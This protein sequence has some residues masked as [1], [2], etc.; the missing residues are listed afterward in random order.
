MS[1]SFFLAALWDSLGLS[2]T[3][4]R[5]RESLAPTPGP[6]H[7]H[8]AAAEAL[9][10]ASL[11]ACLPACPHLESGEGLIRRL[12]F[13]CLTALSDRQIKLPDCQIEWGTRRRTS[14]LKEGAALG[15]RYRLPSTSACYFALLCLGKLVVAA[16]STRSPA[17][18]RAPSLVR[19]CA[20]DVP[21]ARTRRQFSL[22]GPL[23]GT[24]GCTPLCTRSIDRS[25]DIYIEGDRVL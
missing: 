17:H 6:S 21:F 4:S 22:E 5:L 15:G 12:L 3:L 8:Q 24:T 23:G 16:A 1:L 7:R 19:S 2:S 10:E 9:P 14:S 13:V 20:A 25:I 11:P 18:S